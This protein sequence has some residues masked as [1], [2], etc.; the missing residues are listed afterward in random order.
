MDL[1]LISVESKKDSYI[2]VVNKNPIAIDIK[3]VTTSIPSGQVELMGCGKGNYETA[4]LQES[5]ANM[6]KCERL[7]SKEYAILK[8]SVRS[9]RSETQIWGD[10]SINTQFEQLS[11]PVHFKIAAGKL[12]I[13]PDRLVFDQCFPVSLQL[14]LT[15]INMQPN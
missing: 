6:T 14:L 3:Q 12:E 2:L 4:L 10:I 8:L 5:Y 11:I 9:G 13:G 7:R 15:A 1:G